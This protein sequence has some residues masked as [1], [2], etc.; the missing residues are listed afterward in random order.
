MGENNHIINEFSKLE[1]SLGMNGWRRWSTGKLKFDN[2]LCKNQD[3]YW[4]M[5]QKNSLGVWETN[6]SPY[7]SQNTKPKDKKRLNLFVDFD[8]QTI[9]EK[10]RKRKERLVLGP[11]QRTKKAVEPDRD[12]DFNWCDC[13]DLQ[14]LGKK[15]GRAG[16]YKTNGK[17]RCYNIAGFIQNTEKSPEDLRRL[18]L[19]QTQ[20]K[21][22]QY[23]SSK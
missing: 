1:Q 15:A 6:I 4:G 16:N 14:M 17:Y 11:R 9:K 22:H 10:Q 7:S 18:A 13:S 19:N 23:E 3:L 12:T 8:G 20:V 2:A 21:Y 5:R